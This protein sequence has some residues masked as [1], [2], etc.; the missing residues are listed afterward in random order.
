MLLKRTFVAVA[1]LSLNSA[2]ANDSS[3]KDD[4]SNIRRAVLVPQ[5]SLKPRGHVEYI[6]KGHLQLHEPED[7]NEPNCTL[8]WRPEY[9]KVIPKGTKL[10]VKKL[11]YTRD[12]T[13][14][15]IQLEDRS[16][17]IDLWCANRDSEEVTFELLH[18]SLKGVFEL[19][20]E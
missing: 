10:K 6:V 5:T 13:V 14:M 1:I 8:I 4:I 20:R 3:Q 18:N 15:D 19:K 17:F 2:F 12:K 11:S 9:K 7:R 16:I